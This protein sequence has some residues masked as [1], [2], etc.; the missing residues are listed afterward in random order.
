MAAE[1]EGDG[2]FA[3]APDGSGDAFGTPMYEAE[4]TKL[5][6]ESGQYRSQARPMTVDF[7]IG[8]KARVLRFLAVVAHHEQ[9]AGA[10]TPACLAAGRSRRLTVVD[11]GLDELDAV[12]PHR[13]VV[14]FDEIAG[15]A[16]DPLDERD[17]R[18]VLLEAS[19]RLEDDDVAALVVA[20]D[21]RELVHEN[22]LVRLERVLHGRLR[23]L[24]RLRHELVDHEEDHD[25]EKDRLDDLEQAPAPAK[26]HPQQ[27][28]SAG[29]G[30]SREMVGPISHPDPG[31]ERSRR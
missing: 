18:P 9:L 27:Y 28:P 30:R 1:G 29:R 23:D 8:P 25:R 3:D 24:P 15:H 26:A 7:W 20:E 22:E 16:D 6:V 19:G 4:P 11:I 21:R 2:T 31:P 10:D 14:D 13:V 17:V 12:H 5:S